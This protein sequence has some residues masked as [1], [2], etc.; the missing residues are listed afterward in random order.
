MQINVLVMSGK[1]A[2]D[3]VIETLPGGSIKASF[4]LEQHKRYT[5]NG[6]KKVKRQSIQVECWGETA[7][8][9]A[10]YIGK[11]KEII[12]QGELQSNSWKDNDNRWHNRH[13]LKA[14]S[15]DLIG[16]KR[17]PGTLDESF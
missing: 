2:S 17:Q 6:E 9:A 1:A 7:K 10:E 11:G 15:I 12:V 4:I 14:E 8:I 13:S 3:A 5:K 16:A